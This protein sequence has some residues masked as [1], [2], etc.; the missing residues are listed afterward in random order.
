MDVR[1]VNA[2]G[3]IKWKGA[4]IFLSEVLVG[5][6]VGLLPVGE[7]LHSIHFGIVRI[8]YLDE[9][10]RKALNRRPPTTDKKEE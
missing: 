8:G 3:E 7:S 2:N 10:N 9:L 4:L 6:N 1:R 5:A